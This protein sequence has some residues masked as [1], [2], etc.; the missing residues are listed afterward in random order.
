M[1]SPGLP[2]SPERP[3]NDYKNKATLGEPRQTARAN[4]I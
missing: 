4:I 2:I 3:R 1:A